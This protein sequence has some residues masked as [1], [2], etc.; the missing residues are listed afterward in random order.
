MSQPPIAA[1][2]I[3]IPELKL[4]PEFIR[5]TTQQKLFLVEYVSHQNPL[6]AALKAYPL[7]RK[8]APQNQK[9]A[10]MMARELLAQ[11][12]IS[13]LVRLY[14]GQP[15][16]TVEELLAAAQQKSKAQREATAEHVLKLIARATDIT[17]EV[18][19][20]MEFYRGLTQ[21]PACIPRA[22]KDGVSNS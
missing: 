18:V 22:P 12:T 2:A 9:T 11:K 7:T 10:S 21:P 13:K 8:G 17:P 19:Q 3:T 15:E 16:P 4:M 14:F 5:L 20:A 1:P 6:V